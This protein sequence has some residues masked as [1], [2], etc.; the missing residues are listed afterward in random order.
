MTKLTSSNGLTLCAILA[1]GVA[2]YTVSSIMGSPSCSLVNQGVKL[3][4]TARQASSVSPLPASST[5]HLCK[6]G[7]EYTKGTWVRNESI[8]E[9]P[10]LG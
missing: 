10:Y 3:E 8:S 2:T 5:R 4:E 9:F 7:N 1:T 6:L